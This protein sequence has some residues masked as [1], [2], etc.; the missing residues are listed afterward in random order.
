MMDRRTFIGIVGSA[1]LAYTQSAGAEQTGKVWRVGFLASGV[2]PPDGA[3]PKPLR[4]ELQSLGY[5]E[6]VNYRA[7]LSRSGHD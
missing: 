4:E 1:L 7:R 6:G 3:V 5:A 2:R